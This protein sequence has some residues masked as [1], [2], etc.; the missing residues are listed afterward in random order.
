MSVADGDNALEL[1]GDCGLEDAEP[2]LRRL[3][4]EPATRVDVRNCHQLHAAVLQVLL[5]S[6]AEIRGPFAGQFLQDVVEPLLQG[7]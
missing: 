2:L 7:R 5:A 6:R 1:V 3:L 4:Q